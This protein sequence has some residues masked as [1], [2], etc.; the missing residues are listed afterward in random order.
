MATQSDVRRISLSFPETIEN[1][2]RFAFSVRNGKKTKSFVWAWAERVEPKKPRVASSDVVAIRIDANEKQELL[3]SGD[4]KFFT[5][6]HYNNFPAIL[7]RLPY[8]DVAELRELLADAWRIQA[9]RKLVAA[10][11]QERSR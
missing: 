5:E 9:P 2:D 11:D 3:D 8:L 4:K 10:F 6:P 7:V 1:M